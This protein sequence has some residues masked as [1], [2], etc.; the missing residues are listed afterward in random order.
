MNSSGFSGLAFL[1]AL[2]VQS[3]RV[4]QVVTELDVEEATANAEEGG[5][6]AELQPLPII[7]DGEEHM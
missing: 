6:G 7:G 5:E 2:R 3:R 1:A 4:T